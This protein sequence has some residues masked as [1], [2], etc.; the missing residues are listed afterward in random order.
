MAGFVQFMASTN[1]R[2]A[3]IVVGAILIVLGIFFVAD[4]AGLILIIIGL[5]P[6]TAGIFDFCLAAALA[7]MPIK[8]ADIRRR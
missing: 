6:L 3:R 2:I 1:G 7:G 4:T 5:I 8:G